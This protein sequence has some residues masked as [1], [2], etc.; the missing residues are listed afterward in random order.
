MERG[1]RSQ[2]RRRGGSPWLHKRGFGSVEARVV[3]RRTPEGI[4]DAVGD[5]HPVFAV[6]AICNRGPEGAITVAEATE[7]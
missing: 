3:P 5:S 4:L 6:F 2:G 1:E 7:R